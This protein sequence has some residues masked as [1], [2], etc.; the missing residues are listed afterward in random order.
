MN[1]LGKLDESTRPSE[2]S[3]EARGAGLQRN[4]ES[5]REQSMA[6]RLQHNISCACREE[7]LHSRACLL[8]VVCCLV[9]NRLVPVYL[10]VSA[11][12]QFNLCGTLA[13][14]LC[15]STWYKQF[16]ALL[17]QYE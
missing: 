9:C 14:Y 13:V 7:S 11:S 2:E 12:I 4:I 1:K 15:I 17:S 3:T 16:V 6:A 5:T 10:A 8:R